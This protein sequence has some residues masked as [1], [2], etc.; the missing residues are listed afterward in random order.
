MPSIRDSGARYNSTQPKPKAMII[1]SRLATTEETEELAERTC[2]ET[3]KDERHTDHASECRWLQG[4]PLAHRSTPRPK[5]E[6]EYNRK[7]ILCQVFVPVLG[8]VSVVVIKLISRYASLIPNP[9]KTQL[10]NS[11]NLTSRQSVVCFAH[12]LF[13]CSV[14]K[15]ET[16][17]L[18][19]VLFL[20]FC[21][22]LC[23]EKTTEQ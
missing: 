16:L 7:T 5:A 1:G 2:I 10:R 8:R 20:M 21:I 4:K 11:D 12:L 9:I 6:P 17:V 18:F 23:G 3:P 19:F 14:S 15:S 13:Y 22:V